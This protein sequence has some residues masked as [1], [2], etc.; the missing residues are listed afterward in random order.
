MLWPTRGG[1]MT[2]V[3]GSDTL[4]VLVAGPGAYPSLARGE[5]QRATRAAIERPPV[6]NAPD[7]I[8]TREVMSL[9]W[10]WAGLVAGLGYLWWRGRGGPPSARH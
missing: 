5:R 7:P 10:A 8:P 3:D 1:W 2:L 4:A 6:R 9:W